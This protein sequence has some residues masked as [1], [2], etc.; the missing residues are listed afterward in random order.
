MSKEVADFMIFIVEQ[1]ANRFF[2]GSQPVAYA[3]MKESGLWDFFSKTYETSHTVGV[4][5]LLRDA[6]EW[7]DRNGVSYDGVS[8]Q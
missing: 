7:F 6:S 5:Y 2:G 4:D 1:I 8:R 3:A